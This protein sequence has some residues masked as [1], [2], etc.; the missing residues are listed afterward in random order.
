[1]NFI[2]S[3]STFAPLRFT[4]RTK[5]T[6]W[7]PAGSRRN[8]RKINR[9]G[10]SK[11]RS[12]L[13]R[14]A[15]RRSRGWVV[16]HGRRVVRSRR[17]AYRADGPLVSLQELGD[18]APGEELCHRLASVGTRPCGGLAFGTI[19]GQQR[20]WSDPIGYIALGVGVVA[21]AGL[22][23]YMMRAPHPLI[24]LRVLVQPNI[25]VPA[26]LFSIYGFG[27]AATSFSYFSH[28]S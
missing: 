24:P 21:S 18:L 23:V 19:Y 27:S 6:G 10:F 26:L 13:R 9:F 2:F 8:D 28:I 14:R 1:M 7:V 25:A 20:E 5:R 22:P 4:A 11:R 17:R 12:S 16:R 3:R 15:G